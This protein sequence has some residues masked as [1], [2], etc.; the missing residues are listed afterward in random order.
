[1]V[2]NYHDLT[3]KQQVVD[4]S[5]Q[6]P[7]YVEVTCIVNSLNEPPCVLLDKRRLTSKHEIVLHRFTLTQYRNP[8]WNLFQPLL[9]K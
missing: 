2:G 7:F 9:W 4:V 6:I 8:V 1:M 3:M 5:L